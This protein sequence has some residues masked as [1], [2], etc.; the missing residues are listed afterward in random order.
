MGILGINNRTEN[1]KTV[2]HFH[3][4]SDAAKV[5]LVR[6]LG[7][8]KDT[9]PEEIT[10]ELFWRGIRDY[11]HEHKVEDDDLVGVYECL[12]ENLRKNL[13]DFEHKYGFKAQSSPRFSSPN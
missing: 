3:G 12:F 8:P 9:A 2:Q 13:S 5:G 10:L 7:E 11:A 6:R 1:W 4:L